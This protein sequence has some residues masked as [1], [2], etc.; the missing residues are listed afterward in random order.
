MNLYNG[1]NNMNLYNGKNNMN[2]LYNGNKEYIT[3]FRISYTII[4]YNAS[5]CLRG[6]T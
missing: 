6:Y 4:Y 1:K 3:C 2:L 5:Y